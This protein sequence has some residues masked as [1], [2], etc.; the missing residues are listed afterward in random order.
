MHLMFDVLCVIIAITLPSCDE[1]AEQLKPV[2]FGFVMQ[3]SY[4]PQEV[5]LDHLPA[6]MPYEHPCAGF[7]MQRVS[8][9]DAASLRTVRL[10]PL[11]APTPYD[12]TFA[13]MS[14]T[15]S[16]GE[17]HRLPVEAIVLKDVCV[18]PGFL[19]LE[20]SSLR[21]TH[22]ASV[23]ITGP[24]KFRI[25]SPPSTT[26][27]GMNIRVE[28]VKA[29]EHA[30]FRVTAEWDTSRASS[31]K[32]IVKLPCEGLDNAS[33][34]ELPVFVEG[35]IGPRFIESERPTVGSLVPDHDG[36]SLRLRMRTR[37]TQKVTKVESRLF[38]DWS[39]SIFKSDQSLMLLNDIPTLPPSSDEV[40]SKEFTDQLTVTFSDGYVESVG[41][42]YRIVPQQTPRVQQ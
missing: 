10:F 8:G 37:G 39:P 17:C 13:E 34:K 6:R 26:T 16:N 41:V 27:D 14:W 24:M 35:T 12:R 7:G 28:Q 38:A 40:N 5:V 23:E 18:G 19:N 42:K 15:D 29:S 33:V 22:R 11:A 21:S 1:P 3:G 4:V 20:A 31:V 36:Y 2:K 9:R 30:V 25:G 32:E